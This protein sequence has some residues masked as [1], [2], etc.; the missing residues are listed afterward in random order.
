LLKPTDGVPRRAQYARR[1]PHRAST[2]TRFNQAS[3][4]AARSMQAWL[5]QRAGATVGSLVSSLSTTLR[6]FRS[7]ERAL[8]ILVAAI[9]AVA[10]LLAVLPGTS[11]GATGST[12]GRG[13]GVRLAVNGGVGRPADTVAAE[14]P[15]AGTDGSGIGDTAALGHEVTSF[16]PVVIPEGVDTAAGS[17]QA[18]ADSGTFLE[19]GTLLTGY[20]PE[21]DVE[22]GSDLIRKYKVRSGDTLVSIAAKF[23]VSMRTLWWANKLKSK[24]DLHVGQNLRIPPVS[25]L[26]VTVTANDTLD[27]LASKYK[28]SKTRIVKLNDLADPTLVAGQV[29]VLPG[30]KGAPLPTPKPT[31]KPAAKPRPT[32]HSGG[33]RSTHVRSGGANYTGGAFRWPVIGGGNY[34][35]QYFHAGHGAIDIAADYGSPVVAAAGGRVVFAGWKSNGGGWQVWISHGGGMYT[36]YNHMSSLAVGTGQSVGRGQRVGRIGA[37]GWATGPHLHFE[38]WLGGMPWAGGYQTN[39]MRYF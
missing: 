17:E 12:A 8:P 19:D 2:I 34:I 3:V 7:A 29:L 35:S 39:P 11:A 6:P 23:D 28:V 21:T 15:A 9:V 38:V 18:T 27:S 31:P 26:V 32:S 22:D 20:A 10:S 36:T 37:S 16:L 1:R 4:R 24:D 13:Q 25:G 33:G 30:A 14:A 5:G